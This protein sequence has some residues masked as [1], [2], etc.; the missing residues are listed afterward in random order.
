MINLTDVEKEKMVRRVEAGLA[1]GGGQLS[2]DVR[3]KLYDVLSG[4]MSMD[5]AQAE[6][7]AKYMK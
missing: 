4:K 3:Q 1:F 7:L 6:I 2:P 5:D